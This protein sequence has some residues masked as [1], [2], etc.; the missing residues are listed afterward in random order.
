MPNKVSYIRIHYNSSVQLINLHDFGML[1]FNN[2]LVSYIAYKGLYNS[3]VGWLVLHLLTL[4]N[5]WRIYISL[6]I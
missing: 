6:R 2:Y 1:Y 3:Y 5:Y 4:Q